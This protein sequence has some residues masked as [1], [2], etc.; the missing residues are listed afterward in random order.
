MLNAVDAKSR[1]SLPAPYRKTIERNSSE[2]VAVIG[3]HETD[4]C[5][6]GYDRAWGD[7]LNAEL[8][9][10]RAR[11]KQNGT[12]IDRFNPGR[13]AFGLTEDVNVDA[14]GRITLPAFYREH[15]AITNWIWFMADGDTFEMWDPHSLLAYPDMD[16][17]VKAAVRH[18]LAKAGVAHA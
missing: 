3:L 2:S 15:A 17:R 6:I 5:L 4:P 8:R 11:A 16:P 9:E 7:L 12:T 10:D 13:L 1:V 14:T 18:E